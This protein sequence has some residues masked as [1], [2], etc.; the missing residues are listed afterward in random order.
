MSLTVHEGEVR[1]ETDLNLPQNLELSILP[2]TKN[3]L[4]IQPNWTD[5]QLKNQIPDTKKARKQSR[6]NDHAKPKY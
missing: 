5:C 4:F 6:K 3:K 2:N 1:V